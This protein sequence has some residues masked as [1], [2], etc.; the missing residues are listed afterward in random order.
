MSRDRQKQK[1]WETWWEGLEWQ[2]LL[3][4]GV[5]TAPCIYRALKNGALFSL[6]NHS[7]GWILLFSIFLKKKLRFRAIQWC[8][9]RSQYVW[10]S[11]F[12]VLYITAAFP[13]QTELLTVVSSLTTCLLCKMTNNSHRKF[14]LCNFYENK[15][16]D[17]W[18]RNL[19][20]KGCDKSCY[21][22][23]VLFSGA[24]EQAVVYSWAHL[25]LHSCA[26]WPWFGRKELYIPWITTHL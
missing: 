15:A 20:T 16:L 7:V 8:V 5:C 17:S 1:S 9:L 21:K 22:D 19:I 11:E 13:W 10:E 6:Q 2:Q 12:Q 23:Y 25:N 3:F 18:N 26:W 24:C 14:P 4:L